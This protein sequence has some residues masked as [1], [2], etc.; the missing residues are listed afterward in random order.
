MQSGEEHENREKD[1]VQMGKSTNVLLL[2]FQINYLFTETFA[3]NSSLLGLLN[4]LIGTYEHSLASVR[5]SVLGSH[6]TMS[7]VFTLC[8]LIWEPLS[9]SLPPEQ[10]MVGSGP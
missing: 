7:P 10:R 3:C 9:L 8:I 4:A 1:G 6:S 2:P 5:G